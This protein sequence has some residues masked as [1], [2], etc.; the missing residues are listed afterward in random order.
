M[1]LFLALKKA[2][3]IPPLIKFNLNDNVSKKADDEAATLV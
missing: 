2:I 1:T 3:S